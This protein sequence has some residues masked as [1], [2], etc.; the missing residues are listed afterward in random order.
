MLISHSH[1]FIF[2]HVAKVAGVSIRSALEPYCEEP[3]HFKIAR[4]QP[5]LPDGTTNPTYEMWKSALWHAK[6]R[7]VKKQLSSNTFANFY[8]FAFVR[9]PWDWQV[10]MYHFILKR[11][12]HIHHHKVSAMR[13]FDE[14]L[15]WVI[16]TRNPY[17]K[18]ATKHQKDMLYDRNDELLVDFVGHYESLT[19]DFNKVCN[20]IGIQAT[21]PSFNHSKHENYTHYYNKSSIKRVAE[22]F[23]TDI[24][25]FGYTFPS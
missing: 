2:I 15:E 16:A 14:Y 8:K 18:N 24:E 3:Q 25:R 12:D 11:K 22:Y 7:D 4:P 5:T 9:N 21:L 13:S 6:A 10:S 1:R 17:P 20:Q 19:Q 23:Q